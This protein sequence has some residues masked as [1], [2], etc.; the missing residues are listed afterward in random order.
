MSIYQNDERLVTVSTDNT[1]RIWD[2]QTEKELLQWSDPDGSVY[3]MDI[4]SDE[5]FIYTGGHNGVCKKW[6]VTLRHFRIF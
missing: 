1:H 3:N 4:T 2:I 6:E 5:R